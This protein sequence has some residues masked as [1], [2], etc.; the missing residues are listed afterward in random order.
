MIFISYNW[1]LIL[2]FRSG[3]QGIDMLG[4]VCLQSAL[5]FC[6]IC[7]MAFNV[8]AEFFNAFDASP[9]PETNTAF[10]YSERMDLDN[11]HMPSPLI[12]F[13]WLSTYLS[14]SVGSG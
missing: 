1:K 13:L 5:Y 10:T 12:S 7:Q 6:I 14:L 11:F 4:W 2:T 9:Q 8:S 3:L